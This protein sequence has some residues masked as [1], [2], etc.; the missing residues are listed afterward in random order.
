L[1]RFERHYALP[2]ERRPNQEEPVRR[3]VYRARLENDRLIGT[4]EV[5]GHPETRLEWIGF[6]APVIDEHDDGTWRPAQPIELFNGRDLTG[7][8]PL[9]GRRQPGWVVENGILKNLPPTSD[10]VS[11]QK[12]WNFDLHAEYR[13]KPGSNSGIALRGRYEVQILDDYGK[14]PSLQSHGA[15]YSRILPRVNASKPAG[16]W[17]TLDVRLIGR[18]VTVVLN[19]TTI[20]EKGIIE[21]L[22][23]MGHDPYEDRPGPISIQGDH[24]E[25][26]IRKLTITPL[27][28]TR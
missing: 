24:R 7:W 12:F 8:K 27:V 26:E 13:L 20:I 19:G 9:D 2:G 17:Q 4:F 15:I 22:T 1:D 16:E 11:E 28:R 21:G 23:A 10:L 18:E 6:R 5:E 3:G 14:P 25:I